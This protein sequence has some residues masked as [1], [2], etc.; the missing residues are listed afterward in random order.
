VPSL[1]DLAARLR[2]FAAGELPRADVERWLD[3]VLAADPLGAE[4]SDAAPWEEGHEEERLFWRVAYL[5]E[6]SEGDDEALRRVA[7]RIV[8][9][10]ASTASAA[11]TFELL[12]VL[13]DQDRFCAIVA[14]HR[15]GVISRTGFLSVLAGSGYP[16]HAKLWLEHADGAALDALCERLAAGEYGTVAR[17]LERA[18]R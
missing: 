2:A 5:V 16:S 1:Y 6:S 4:R 15:R 8:G 9:C 13:L 7:G 12:P 17:M 11:D 14:K 18:P 3:A 10:L